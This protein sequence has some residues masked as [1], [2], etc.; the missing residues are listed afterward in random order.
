MAISA[1]RVCLLGPGPLG[2]AVAETAGRSVDRRQDRASLGVT[3]LDTLTVLKASPQGGT[4][5]MSR[6]RFFYL[7]PPS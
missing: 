3:K 4:L 5:H 1:L 6:A 2:C 7:W